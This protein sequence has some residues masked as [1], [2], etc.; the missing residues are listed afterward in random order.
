MACDKKQQTKR[1][2]ILKINNDFESGKL[3]AMIYQQNSVEKLRIMPIY[4]QTFKSTFEI[5]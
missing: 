5:L 2:E 3:P 4:H 1:L